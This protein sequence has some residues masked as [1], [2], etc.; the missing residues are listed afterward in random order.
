[1]TKQLNCM[2][3]SASLNIYY[4][5][6]SFLCLIHVCNKV[7]FPDKIKV[8]WESS[9]N[10]TTYNK[11]VND[12]RYIFSFTNTNLLGKLSCPRLEYFYISFIF[13]LFTG[14]LTYFIFPRNAVVLIVS[15]MIFKIIINNWNGCRQFL[16]NDY[17]ETYIYQSYFTFRPVT[18]ILFYLQFFWYR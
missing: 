2:Q 16:P 7:T 14:Y 3:K 12:F 15:T 9:C 8:I 10:L 4:V 6:Q 17:K 5:F 11:A 1:M 13:T 18:I